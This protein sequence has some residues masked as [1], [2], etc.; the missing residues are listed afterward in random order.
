MP[1][2]RYRHYRNPVRS[3]YE[4]DFFDPKTWSRSVFGA[5]HRSVGVADRE[6]DEAFI[7]DVENRRHFAGIGPKNFRRIDARVY[8]DVCDAL[9]HS[10]DVD[11]SD[12]SV[13]I[14]DGVVEL[15]GS[16]LERIQ[17][18]IAEDITAGVPGVREVKNLLT[19]KEHGRF[20][21]REHGWPI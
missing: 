11:A 17:K 10:P 19:V 12:I 1:D 6:E 16:A 8:E 4:F 9:L 20:G 3:R 7:H 13:K 15:S 2:T 21:V 18:Y 5:G 14:E